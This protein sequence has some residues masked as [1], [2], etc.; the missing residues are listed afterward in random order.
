LQLDDLRHALLHPGVKLLDDLAL[1]ICR[2][3]Q[4]R[5]PHFLLHARALLPVVFDGSLQTFDRVAFHAGHF[6]PG[7]LGIAH[8]FQRG[9]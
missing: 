6:G 3:V 1:L 8:R 9:H 5:A 7:L 4:G 2:Q